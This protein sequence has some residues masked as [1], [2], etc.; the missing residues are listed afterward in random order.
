[1]RPSATWL[2][3]VTVLA[4]A[5]SAPE[6]WLPCEDLAGVHPV[7][8]LSAPEDL[9]LLPDGHTLVMGLSRGIAGPGERDDRPPG[10]IAFLDTR[11]EEVRIVYPSGQRTPG[12]NPWGDP[13]CPGEPDSIN[14]HGIDLSRRADG[15]LQLL[16]VNHEGREAVEIFEVLDDRV[17]W[18]GCVLGPADA[19]MNDVVA[20]ADGGFLVTD[21]IDPN[22]ATR[23]TLRGI[24]GLDTSR[25]YAWQP[26]RALAPVPG[27]IGPLPNGIELSPDER[28]VYVAYY[29]AGQV[30]RIDRATGAV[31]ATAEVPQPD[32]LTWARDGRLLVAS[33]TGDLRHHVV[34]QGSREGACPMPWQLLAL[35]PESLASERLFASDGRPVGGATVAVEVGEFVWIGAFAGDRLARLRLGR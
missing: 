9:A 20:L 13:A 16:V 22:A 25:V 2:F 31:L 33:H 18:R 26:G 3:S 6:P 7:C 17:A 23:D 32:N 21:M 5:C 34:C 19:S 24:L 15:R 28:S 29:G 1:M 8:G 4:T 11:S 35:D 30:R 10:R 27:T 14:P 12:G